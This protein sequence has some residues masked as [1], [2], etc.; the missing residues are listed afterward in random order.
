MS[1]LLLL[2]HMMKTSNHFELPE[3]SLLSLRLNDSKECVMMSN[4]VQYYHYFLKLNEANKYNKFV[5][6]AEEELMEASHYCEMVVVKM[7]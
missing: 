2:D 3:L 1:V 6:N 4:M 7:V 5:M